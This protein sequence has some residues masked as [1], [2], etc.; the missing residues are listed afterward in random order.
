M[1]LLKLNVRV[2]SKIL[3]ADIGRSFSNKTKV[4]Y[5]QEA[6]LDLPIRQGGSVV[7]D[8][9][10][11]QQRIENN[12]GFQS[13]SKSP[14]VISSSDL[15]HLALHNV[16][17]TSAWQDH[18]DVKRYDTGR[19]EIKV[20]SEEQELSLTSSDKTNLLKG[21]TGAY[22]NTSNVSDNNVGIIPTEA[23][24]DE[25]YIEIV[26]PTSINL[27]IR[28]CERSILKLK[29]VNKVE[30]DL[31][32]TCADGN[33]SVDKARGTNIYL[34]CGKAPIISKDLIEGESVQITGG[35]LQAKKIHGNK[36]DIKSD[37]TI[38]VSSMY[39]NGLARLTADSMVTL[40]L[41]NGPLTIHSRNGNVSVANI[42]GWFDV[43]AERGNINLQVNKLRR[44]TL[45]SAS[46]QQN[47]LTTIGCKA[48]T[49]DGSLA[50]SLDPEAQAS[51]S[52][53]C[54]SPAGRAMVTINSETF[55][56]FDQSELLRTSST[57][58]ANV[59]EEHPERYLRRG[60]LTGQITAAN[61]QRT[62][63]SGKI[64]L[65]SA[66]SQ[67]LFTTANHPK[68][69][70]SS[71]RL[72]PSL[73]EV[74]QKGFDLELTA[75]GHVRLETIS[76]MEVIKRKHG[77]GGNDKVSA[78]KDYGRTATAR[79]GVA[80]NEGSDSRDKPLSAWR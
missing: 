17:I 31:T 30:G 61:V 78:P 40:G 49:N 65:N 66:H 19:Y 67:A 11:N 38:G 76:W 4:N 43:R 51:V 58:D 54:T 57:T 22:S 60:Y 5:S 13:V 68:S 55:Q 35:L 41:C 24:R 59:K 73:S 77:F 2:N 80:P 21:I 6:L 53:R 20:D 52:A 50:V 64:D 56:S 28:A 45:G 3:T 79:L 27:C 23:V 47:S 37:S 9:R 63:G 42:D 16:I 70:E 1:R 46:R 72:K 25:G 7:L 12:I 39:C 8:L 14:D 32:V 62:S 29:I 44:S 33:V 15:T 71:T 36:L 74:E 34:Q 75:H 48:I 18:I 10:N 26:T 69:I